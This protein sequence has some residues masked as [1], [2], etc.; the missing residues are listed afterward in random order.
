MEADR[1]ANIPGIKIGHAQDLKAATGC[2]VVICEQG[3]V[4]GV[5][6][7]GGAPG[8]RETDLIN[9]VNLVEKIHAVVLAGGS[10]FGLDAAAGVM[11]YLEEK[12]A[13]FDTGIA[14]VPIVAGAVLFD[15]NCGD[16]RIRP[17]KAMGYQ[18]CL[19]AGGGKVDEGTVGAGTGATVG[20]YFGAEYAM[21]GGLGACCL[22]SGDLMVGAV[23]AVNCLGDVVDPLDRIILAGALDEDRKSFRHTEE[24]ILELNG[25][26][27]NVFAGNTTIGVVVTNAGLTK[28]QAGKVAS[29]AHNG[30]AKTIRP[31]HTMFDGDTIFTMATGQLIADVN[32]VGILAGRAVEQAVIR[33]VRQ[34]SSLAG[35]ISYGELEGK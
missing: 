35:Y 6:V 29:M 9:P 11:Q 4:A 30:Y 18:A 23:V 28:A 12:G 27:S 34:A 31:V 26:F 8:T 5:D 15:L 1:I 10:A 33:G 13:G 17:D 14:R 25:K 19:A 7:R 22:K 2:T 24:A 32:V 21:K 20:K 3:A 16:H